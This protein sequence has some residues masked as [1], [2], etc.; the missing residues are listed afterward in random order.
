MSI[1]FKGI[2]QKLI[3]DQVA[4]IIGS[5]GSQMVKWVIVPSKNKILRADG[6]VIEEEVWRGTKLVVT[7]VE[8]DT[9]DPDHDEFD[10]EKCTHVAKIQAPED[11]HIEIVW[12][13]LKKHIGECIKPR[14]THTQRQ[15]I[16]NYK[17]ICPHDKIGLILGFEGCHIR[18]LKET[19]KSAIVSETLPHI[20]VTED[21]INF[22]CKDITFSPEGFP[23]TDQV[24]YLT[25]RVEGKFFIE[26]SACVENWWME[27]ANMIVKKASENGS[28]W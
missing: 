10:E 19:V 9:D 11:E 20:R 17:I 24:V 4:K 3:V 18:T 13:F 15:S 6:E 7:I 12:T 8:I 27:T 28:G 21:K 5:K 1:K 25:V 22:P 14:K 23:E 16:Y 2:E 26:V